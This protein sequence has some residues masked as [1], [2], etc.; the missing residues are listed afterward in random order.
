[1]LLRFV[2]PSGEGGEVG[3]LIVGGCRSGG[4]GIERLGRGMRPCR[5]LRVSLC[6]FYGTW[7]TDGWMRPGGRVVRYVLVWGWAGCVWVF[8]YLGT[9]K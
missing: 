5:V 2:D 7:R 8:K 3:G 4:T 9:G 1:M 6:S